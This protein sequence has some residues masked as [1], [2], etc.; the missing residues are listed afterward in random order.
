MKR[1]NITVISVI[2]AACLFVILTILQN[3][4]VNDEPTTT[5]LVSNADV[6]PDT[7]L[8][9]EWFSETIVPLKL[10]ISNSVISSIG[11]ING[12]Y[13]KEI[14]N[15]G[16][17]LFKQ[18]VGSKEEL[19]IINAPEGI[20]KIAIEIKNPQNAIAYQV[21]P[22]DRIHLYFSGRYGAIKESITQFGLENVSKNDNS[23]YTTCL[24]KNIPILGIYD[25]SGKSIESDK[26]TRLDTV[27]IGVDSQM[28]KI[29][30]NLRNQGT[31][32]LTK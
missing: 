15:K 13:A 23:M 26:F 28:A 21:K 7:E 4:L 11:D 1:I 19:K 8:K 16:Q 24:L 32:D 3:K 14:I 2:I 22:K 27:V 6:K 17:I 10:A 20:E 18:D 30:N 12:K 29:I 9:P 25:E 31:F 5:V